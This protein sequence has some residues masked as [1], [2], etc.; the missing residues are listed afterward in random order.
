MYKFFI[1]IVAFL[2]IGCSY[3]EYKKP[4]I[5]APQS[6]K[7]GVLYIDANISNGAWWKKFDD[8]NLNTLVE[9][10][11]NNNNEL[12]A[13]SKTVLEAE[14]KLKSASYA[15][16]P[17]LGISGGGFTGS[18]INSNILPSSQTGNLIKNASSGQTKFSGYNAGFS[19]SFSANILQNISNTEL[20]SAS[21]EYKVAYKNSVLT[22]IISQSV[23]SYFML[24]GLQNQLLL[25]T[26]LLISFEALKKIENSRYANGKSSLDTVLES[27]KNIND[28]KNQIT[29]TKNA[30][31]KTE[32]AIA[33]LLGKNPQTFA[34]FSDINKL[35]IKN[36][37]DANISSSVLKNRPDILMAEAKLKMANANLN[38]ANSLFFPTISLTGNGGIASIALS[39]LFGVNTGFWLLSAAASMPILNASSFEEIKAAEQG[40]YVAYYEYMQSVKAAFADVDSALVNYQNSMLIYGNSALSVRLEDKILNI[41]NSKYQNGL[42]DKSY[43][44]NAQIDYL[45]LGLKLNE[46]KMNTLDSIVM[47]YGAMTND[48]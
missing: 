7:S 37:I 6:S 29:S 22:S 46:A 40:K 19:P 27:E 10:V 9:D 11:L 8:K 24:C 15:W 20:A 28:I 14:A 1:F 26:K 47:A 30:I 42:K 2:F 39:N 45:K 18:T 4:D 38:L 16:M 36:K 23:G 12:L 44:L 43:Y 25:Q 5:S 32:N 34:N 41:A 48:F 17:T 21:L 33:V 3:K 13:A 35:D 31:S